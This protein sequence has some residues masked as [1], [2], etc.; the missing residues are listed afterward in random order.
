MALSF[1]RKPELPS[2]VTLDL[3]GGPVQIVVRRNARAKSY[4][5]SLSVRGDPVL[6]FPARG[7]WPDAEAFLERNRGWLEVRLARR[8]SPY[9]LAEGGIIPVRGVDHGIAASGRLRGTVTVS[10]SGRDP[11]LTVPGA[12]EHISRRLVDW[13]K[14]EARRDLEDRCAVHAETL[15][16]R[17]AALKLRDQSTRWGSCSSSRTLNFNWRLILAPP[18]VLDYVAAHEVAHIIEMNHAPAFWAQVE[19]ALPSY[20]SGRAWLKA[21]GSKLMAI[22]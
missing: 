22:S 1:L 3:S 8:H 19:R 5:L 16:V 20:R 7:R 17:I 11:V 12:P 18:H 4:R 15:G 2:S 9:R 13:L 21:N 10:S 14:S 6:T